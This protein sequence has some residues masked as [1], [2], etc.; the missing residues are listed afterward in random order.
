[1]NRAVPHDP[2]PILPQAMRRPVA[3]VAVLAALV[4]LTLALTFTGDSA[5]ASFDRA[6]QPGLESSATAYSAW[7]RAV[8]VAGHPGGLAV[9]VALLVGVSLLRRRSRVAVLVVLGTGLS[10]S[11]TSALKPLVGR[12]IHGIDL[13]YPKRPHGVGDRAGHDRRAARVAPPEPGRRT[14]AAVRGRACGRRGR[15]M[16]RSGAWCPIN[17]R[18]P[19]AAGARRWRWFL[20][21]RGSSTMR[22]PSG[23]S[24]EAPEHRLDQA[25]AQ[26][27][28]QV[29][30]VQHVAVT[31]HALGHHRHRAGGRTPRCTRPRRSGRGFEV[32]RYAGSTSRSSG[33]RR[34]SRRRRCPSTHQSGR[35]WCAPGGCG[36]S[37]RSRPRCPGLHALVSMARME[38]RVGG[39]T[40]QTSRIQ[41]SGRSTGAAG[42]ENVPCDYIRGVGSAF[43]WR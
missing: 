24:G 22:P 9:L 5:P 7:A 31:A 3:I 34:S 23:R 37:G 42:D 41:V 38:G 11:V 4:V 32:A 14:G 26:P 36:T 18:T 30:S 6:V 8:H 27:R 25:F 10:I 12:T 39:P 15:C 16:V 43:K 2:P 13:S 19:W 20:R 28:R 33:S 17:R 35:R 21:Q 29:P 40:R 1:V